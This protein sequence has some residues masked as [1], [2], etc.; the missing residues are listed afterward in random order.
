MTEEQQWYKGKAEYENFGLSLAS[1]AEAYAGRLRK[2][3][4]LTKRA[5]ESAIRAD[6]KETG[7]TR[8]ENAAVREAAFGNAAAAKQAAAAG[9][10]LTPGSPGVQVEA[11]LAL[12]MAGESVRA[13]SMA[14][15]LNRRFPQRDGRPTRGTPA[16]SLASKQ[17][18]NKCDE[19][20]W[21]A[22]IT[23]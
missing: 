23:M 6:N 8:Q 12:A 19:L 16:H 9:L 7:A 18:T 11:A 22:T 13:E 5:V 17:C 21:Q 10:K 4:E 20:S 14:K 2:A 1:D 15:E 3:R